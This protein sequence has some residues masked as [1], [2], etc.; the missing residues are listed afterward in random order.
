MKRYFLFLSYDGAGYHGW[1]RQPNGVSVEETVEHA[2]SLLLRREVDIVGAGRT[3][4]G[5]NAKCMPAHFDITDEDERIVKP[6]LRGTFEEGL[7]YKLNKIL[8]RDIAVDKVVRVNGV[9][10][11]RFDACERTYHYYVTT[12]KNVFTFPHC[13]TVP[14]GIDFNR[15]NEAARLLVRRDDFASFAKTH[16]DVKTTVCDVRRAVW[17]NVG[18]STWRFE[19]TADRF[20]RN[21]VRAVVGTLLDVGRGRLCVTDVEKVLAHHD[22]CAAGES[23]PGGAL[24][25]HSVKYPERVFKYE[26]KD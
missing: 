3:D 1:Q 2:L 10:H 8:P 13:F 21:M 23:V 17:E 6:A 5:V 25:L 26:H 12:K 7:E 18:D 15:M 14:P 20:L 24:F 11:A 16:T 9:A 4:T 22:R 19:I